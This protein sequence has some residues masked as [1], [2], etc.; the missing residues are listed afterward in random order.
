MKVLGESIA[1]KA[2]LNFSIKRYPVFWL[3]LLVT[4]ALDYL[5]TVNFVSRDGTQA[6]ANQIVRFLMELAGIEFGVLIAKALQLF[7]V[8]VFASLHQRLG[9]IFLL[10]VILLNT[11]AVFVN[12]L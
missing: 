3:I 5:T 11:W 2:N 10:V 7:A 8:I 1:F 9:N 6:E 4:M 12:T